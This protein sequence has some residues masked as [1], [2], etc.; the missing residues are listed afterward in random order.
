[1]S[2]EIRIFNVILNCVCQFFGFWFLHF[3]RV[4]LGRAFPQL[5]CCDADENHDHDHPQHHP[6]CQGGPQLFLLRGFVTAKVAMVS[7]LQS[8]IW[9]GFVF[10]SPW[11]PYPSHLENLIPAMVSHSLWHILS[12]IPRSFQAALWHQAQP[13]LLKPCLAAALWADSLL[14]PSSSSCSFSSTLPYILWRVSVAAQTQSLLQL[15]AAFGFGLWAFGE[16]EEEGEKEKTK[17]PHFLKKRKHFY[18]CWLIRCNKSNTK[19]QRPSHCV[20]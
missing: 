5:W 3:L 8:E 9:R 18:H 20:E 17:V 14:P 2:W 11:E 15:G 16:A 4:G 10:V 1:M 19:S 6:C 7:P 13:A 12:L